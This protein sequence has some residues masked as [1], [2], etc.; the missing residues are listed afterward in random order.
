MKAAGSFPSEK[1]R[2][3]NARSVTTGLRGMCHGCCYL[4]IST[5]TSRRGGKLLTI[6]TELD[7]RRESRD[8]EKSRRR[9]CVRTAWVPCTGSGIYKTVRPPCGQG[10]PPRGGICM[11][12]FP[13]ESKEGQKVPAVFRAAGH[14]WGPMEQEMG[15]GAGGSWGSPCLGLEAP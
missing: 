15:R 2:I 9:G 3:E 13:V 5:P 7:L 4:F 12:T 8:K 10:Q 11:S 6:K 1:L 14:F